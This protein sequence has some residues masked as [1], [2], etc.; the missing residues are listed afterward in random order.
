MKRA[1]HLSN[2]QVALQF[3]E[4]RRA[5]A[6]HLLLVKSF[7][8]IIIAVAVDPLDAYIFLPF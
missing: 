5:S 6:C 8:I 3:L 7:Y 4:S 1:H 2:V